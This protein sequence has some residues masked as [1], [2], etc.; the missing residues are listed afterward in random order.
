M[1]NLTDEKQGTA[2]AAEAESNKTA[3]TDLGKFK[4]VKALLSAY[5]SLE[6]EFTRRSQR[7]K[8]LEEKSKTDAVQAQ[9]DTPPS[10]AQNEGRSLYEQASGDDEVKNAIIADYLKAVCS[11]RGAPMAT[12]GVA[13]PSPKNRPATIKE[14]GKLAREFLKNNQED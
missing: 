5:A 13:V 2:D 4:D 7:L 11:G 6:A 3:A 8:E 1:D 9:Q 10:S 12:G 14:A